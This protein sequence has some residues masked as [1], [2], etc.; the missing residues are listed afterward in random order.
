M[1]EQLMT[2]EFETYS[3]FLADGKRGARLTNSVG[4]AKMT[5]NRLQALI[6]QG[7]GQGRGNGY[8]P[9]ICVTRG[10]SP[11][12]SNHFVAVTSIQE[13]PLHLMSGLEYGATRVATWLGAKEVRTQFPIWPWSGHPHPMSGLNPVDDQKLPETIGLLEIAYEAGIKHGCYVGAPDQPYVATTDLVLT[14]N[15]PTGSRLV[16]W[17]CKPASILTCAG[18]RQNRIA[19]RIELERRYAKAVGATHV[20]YD[21]THVS[22]KLVANLDWLEP[23]RQE[24]TDA[25]LCAVRKLFS[26]AYNIS[27]ATGTIEQRI[28]QAAVSIGIGVSSAQC[29]FRAAAWLGQI[30]IDLSQPVLMSRPMKVGGNALK[31]ALRIALL[32]ETA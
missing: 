16:F 8:M 13:K 1:K 11:R 22:T 7:F 23:P 26:D 4:R 5:R 19:E 30:E 31:R 32:G 27:K 17:T 18:P 29:H 2:A 14:I 28:E 12:C 3:E 9:W 15:A 10:N 21:G 20:V 6:L 24:R 25:N